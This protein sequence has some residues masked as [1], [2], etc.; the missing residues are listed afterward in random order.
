MATHI[1]QG[2]CTKRRI[3]APVEWHKLFVIFFPFINAQP[4]VPIQLFWNLVFGLWLAKSLRP[5]GPVCPAINSMRFADEAGFVHLLHFA[6]AITTGT[7]V[8]HLR[9]HFVFS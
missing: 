8:T 5:Y 4:Q 2:T 7:L 9:D 6:H 3:A 1:S